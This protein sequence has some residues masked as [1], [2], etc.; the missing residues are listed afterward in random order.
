MTIDPMSCGV[1]N[2]RYEGALALTLGEVP[3]FQLR[4]NLSNIDVGAAMTLA[5]SPGTVTGTLTGRVDLAGRGLAAAS[6]ARSLHGSVSVNL[7]DGSIKNLGLVSAVV[8]ATSGRPD[9]TAQLSKGSRD[10][11]FS[12][13]GTTLTVTNGL[14]TTNDLRFDSKDLTATAGGTI[15]ADGSAINLQGQ[16][17]LSDAL[18]QQAGRDLVRYTQEQGRVTIPIAVG[19]SADRLSVNVDAANLAKRAIRNRADEEIGSAIKKGLGS[20]FK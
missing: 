6:V 4:A 3:D 20:L 18:S 17:Q 11:P 19:G 7:R 2:G 14:A 16:V 13:L 12:Q 15:A 10:E 1:F 5:G 9:S 8:L